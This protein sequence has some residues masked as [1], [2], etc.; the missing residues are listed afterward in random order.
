MMGDQWGLRPPLYFQASRLACRSF[1]DAGRRQERSTSETQDLRHS[2]QCEHHWVD[3]CCLLS[4]G[5]GAD[6]PRFCLHRQQVGTMSLGT[7][8]LYS[9]RSSFLSIS[10]E[11][12]LI[13][14]FQGICYTNIYEKVVQSKEWSVLHL[15]DL[16]LVDK[17][18]SELVHPTGEKADYLS[19]N[20]N[21]LWAESWSRHINSPALAASLT[22]PK[23]N[24][25]GKRFESRKCL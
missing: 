22:Q 19:S 2:K 20:S 12:D 8:I 23:R 7:Q 17:V 15:Q 3:S 21:S 25:W 24:P 14:I 18:L 5:Y 9:G 13:S 16:F 4:H 1:L 11:G 10:P 6:G